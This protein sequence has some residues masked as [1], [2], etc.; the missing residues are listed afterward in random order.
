[1]E[2]LGGGTYWEGVGLLGHLGNPNHPNPFHLSFPSSSQEVGSLHHT[3]PTLHL[4]LSTASQS[5]KL[6]GSGRSRRLLL[7]VDFLR[8]LSQ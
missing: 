7:S 2:V 6:G 3:L 8:L 4:S 5:Q 1:M